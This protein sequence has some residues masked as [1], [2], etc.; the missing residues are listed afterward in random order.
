MAFLIL[1]RFD[2][3]HVR[4]LPTQ[5]QRQFPDV[6]MRI[7]P[8]LASA[9]ESEN[10]DLVLLQGRRGCEVIVTLPSREG[11]SCERQQS[12]AQSDQ[13]ESS[14]EVNSSIHTDHFPMKVP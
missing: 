9:E 7:V 12:G 6:A 1:H 13:T 3:D 4:I 5:F 10:Q 14:T 11:A 8:R 2:A